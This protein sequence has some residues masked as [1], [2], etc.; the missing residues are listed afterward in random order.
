[1]AAPYTKYLRMNRIPHM[2]CPG[3]GIGIIVKAL[4]RAFDALEWS[5]D[6]LA[7]ISG[8]GCTSRAPGYMNM[9]TLHTTHGRAISFAT[10]VKFARPN[11]HVV[12]ISG[13]GDAS[14]IGGNHL[15]HACRRNIDMTLVIVNNFIYGMTGGQ[16]SPTTPVGARA[17][18][19]PWG[20]IDIPFN[21]AELAKGAGASYVARGHVGSGVQLERL[22]RGGLDHK[23][24]SVIE[25]L[26][27]CH[28]QYGRRNR[29]ADPIDLIDHIAKSTVNIRKAAKM[30]DGDMEGKYFVGL[31]HKDENRREYC[32]GYEQVIERAQM[33]K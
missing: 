28:T 9:H 25:V 7:L 22:I 15:I 5:P 29:L 10:G 4:T 18:T 26:S 27:N 24:F 32:K 33:S 14:A 6:D 11:K 19:S 12:V 8:I 2:W 23:G 21:I 3:C 31:I 17:A 16:Y 13:D 1:M 30:S 20:N